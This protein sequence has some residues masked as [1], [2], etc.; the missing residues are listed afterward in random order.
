M[1]KSELRKE[2]KRRRNN[3]SI[4]EKAIFD[5][6]IFQNLKLLDWMSVTY[7]HAYLTLDRFNEPDTSQII[8]WL[9]EFYPHIRLV[10]SQS[11][12]GTGHM[13]HYLLNEK[14][15]L[16]AN[17]YGILEPREGELVSESLIDLVLV[18]LLVVDTSGNRV[19]YG[20]GFYDRF[21][22]KC[23]EDVKSYGISFFEPVECISDVGEWD[24]RLTNCITPLKI[25]SFN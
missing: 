21:L 24:K 9:N 11:D 15:N 14:T 22:F 17:A 2:Y 12:F 5:D 1:T 10:I 20:K 13:Q 23:R 16:L 25:Y 7:V 18:P 4:P 3:L 19:G 6:Q 8:K